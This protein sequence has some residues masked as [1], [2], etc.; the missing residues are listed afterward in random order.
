MR[1][2]LW[3]RYIQLLYNGTQY[4]ALTERMRFR[5]QEIEFYT[6][7]W[8][9]KKTKTHKAKLQKQ[10]VKQ[11]N[12]FSCYPTYS[13]NA[14]IKDYIWH[15]PKKLKIVGLFV[16]NIYYMYKFSLF[17]YLF[18]IISYSRSFSFHFYIDIKETTT[19]SYGALVWR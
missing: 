10:F 2:S 5:V 9:L 14:I 11:W 18:F 8:Y 7:T 13:T 17:F 16:Q 3:F 6:I 12:I 19:F 4:F 15:L 1:S